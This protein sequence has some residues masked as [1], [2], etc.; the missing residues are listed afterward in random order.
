[1]VVNGWRLWSDGAVRVNPAASKEPV[2]QHVLGKEKKVTTKTT[3]NRNLPI[4]NEGGLS[5]SG[6][7]VFERVVIRSAF[8]QGQP[9]AIVLLFRGSCISRVAVQT[10]SFPSCGVHRQLS[11]TM[12]RLWLVLS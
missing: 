2:P 4:P 5:S 3:T 11:P 7:G 8:P 1:M 12:I 6:D 10:L 9:P